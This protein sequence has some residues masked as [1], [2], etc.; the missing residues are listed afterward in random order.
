MNLGGLRAPREHEIDQVVWN[1]IQV[2]Q[3]K[4]NLPYKLH[5]PTTATA[6]PA[7][8]VA[9]ITSQGQDGFHVQLFK[10]IEYKVLKW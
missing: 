1:A 3:D 6:D 4:L 8:C 2:G 9:D 7:D 5:M 10:S